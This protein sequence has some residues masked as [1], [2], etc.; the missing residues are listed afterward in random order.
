MALL[1]TTTTAFAPFLR[2]VERQFISIT[3]PSAPP[4]KRILS[5]MRYACS[6]LSDIPQNTSPSVL[7]RAKPSTIAMIPEVANSPWSDNPKTNSI[8]ASAEQI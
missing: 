2:C 5:P 3:S 7:W 4:S 1:G 6:M 8:I